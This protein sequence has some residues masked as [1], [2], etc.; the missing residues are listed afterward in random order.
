MRTIGPWSNA[1]RAAIVEAATHP[2]ERRATSQCLHSDTADR[3]ALIGPRMPGSFRAIRALTIALVLL[4]PAAS[5]VAAAGPS[6]PVAGHQPQFVTEREAGRWQDCLWASASMLVDKWTAGRILISREALRR[7]SGDRTGGS[8]LD[9]LVVALHRIGLTARTSPNGGSVVTWASLRTRLAAGGG[10]VLL[11]DDSQ[12]PRWYGRW[13]PA[14]WN[15]TGSRD[16]HAIYLDRY[17]GAHDRY[18]MMDPLAAASWAGEW[19][20]GRDLRA[21]AWSTR[22]SALFGLMT[23]AATQPSFA[24]VRLRAPV[25]VAGADALHVA[26]PIATTPRRW[27]MPPIG[28]VVRITPETHPRLPSQSIVLSIPPVVIAPASTGPAGGGAAADK[29]TNGVLN[30]TVPYPTAAG[31]Y[32]VA[33]TLQDRRGKRTVARST[34]TLYVPGERQATIVAT[35]SA[36]PSPIGRFSFV[37]GV[38]NTGSATWSDPDWAPVLPLAASGPRSTRLVAT[39]VLVTPKGSSAPL[40][41]API[42]PASI[43]LDAVPFAPGHGATIMATIATPTSPGLWAL[44]LDLVDDVDGSFAAHG[45]R[46]GT[47]LVDLVAAVPGLAPLGDLRP[48]VGPDPGP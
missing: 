21:F 34:V 18:W 28:V 12:L 43:R 7:L 32:R 26:W 48:V 42:A 33:I 17:D 47:I 20:S 25:A 38:T 44:T 8:S 30:A 36:G 23:P 2:R 24:G 40:A 37:A 5:V 16:N 10:A 1:G 39:W 29:R 15:N 35:P 9:R 6:R 19:I 41:L 27:T 11:G 45:S 14:F 4:L 46:P 31:T 3:F 13:D 22:A